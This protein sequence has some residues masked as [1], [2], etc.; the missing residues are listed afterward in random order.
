[1]NRILSAQRTGIPR[2]DLPVRDGPYTTRYNRYNR[3]S[4]NGE[5]SEIPGRLRGI[6][7]EDDDSGGDR[8]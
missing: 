2:R 3:S 1:M 7:N 8:A 6:V 5:W 4:K